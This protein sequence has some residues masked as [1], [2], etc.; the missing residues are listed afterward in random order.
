MSGDY[1]YILLEDGTAEITRYNG[2][3][4]IL[5]I[6]STLDGHSVI[7]IG[8]E[9]FLG[10][11]SLTITVGRDSYAKQYCIDHDIKYMYFDSLDWLNN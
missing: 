6:P 8:D 9:A 10:C 5:V 2:K 11:P 4:P 3:T 1:R 7:S